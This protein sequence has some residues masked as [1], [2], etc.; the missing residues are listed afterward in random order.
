MATRNIF[1]SISGQEAED[2]LMRKGIEGSFIVRP[3]QSIPGDYTLSVKVKQGVTHVRIQHRGDCYDCY[4][5]EEFATLTE[6]VQYYVENPGQ[7]REKN[8]TVILLTQPIRSEEITSERWFHGEIH[9]HDAEILLLSKGQNGSY[10]VRTSTHSP[11][12]FV[13]TT[14]VMDEISHIMIQHIDNKFYIS[15][16]PQFNTL[17]ELVEYYEKNNI[18][19]SDG[20]VIDLQMPFC[21]TSFLPHKIQ[22]RVSELSKPNDKHFGKAEFEEEYRQIV[23][24]GTRNLYVRK[25]G[26]K[27]ENRPEID[28]RIFFHLTILV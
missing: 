22:Q 11:G 4:G 18:V 1:H 28:S 23:D 8:G 25:E 3:S 7:L 5:G 17:P 10:L 14:R 6:L 2:V 19:E 12:N 21:C 27:P 24:D 9:G 26:V 16:G 15:N 13:L 20:R